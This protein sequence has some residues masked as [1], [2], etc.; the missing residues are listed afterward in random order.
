[1]PMT[2]ADHP[3]GAQRL[4]PVATAKNSATPPK[5]EVPFTRLTIEKNRSPWGKAVGDIDGDGFIDALA[6]F[7]DDAVY[8]YHYP[9]WTKHRIGQNGG[10]DLQVADL[11]GD[12]A[13]DV[14]TNGE[15]IVWYENPRCSGGNPASRS[16][17]RHVIDATTGSH[18]VTIGDLNGDGKLD[19]VTRVEFGPTFVYLQQGTDAWTKIA[20]P[21]ADDGNG[22][23]LLDV[24]HDGRIDL[25][26]N[27]YWLEHPS[28]P[29]NGVWVRH[30]FAGWP[31]G[32]SVMIGD[33]NHDGR[34]DVILSPSES[35]GRIAWFEMPVDPLHAPWIEHIILPTASYIH[36][37]RLADFNHDGHLDV[38]FAE[39]DQSGSNRI[40]IS[41]NDGTGTS[42]TLQVL[43]TS[44]G[45]NLAIGDFDNDGDVDIL[46][47][48]WRRSHLDL[49]RNDSSTGGPA[50]YRVL[51]FSKTAGFRHASIPDGIAAIQR[52]GATHHFMADATEDSTAFTDNQLA[53]YKAI[54][55]LNPSGDILD[56]GQRAAFQR[57]IEQG[58]GF[59]GIHNAAALLSPTMD[60][61]E[62]Y[63]KLVG[64][65]YHSE[66]PTQPMRL[67]VV[68]HAHPSTAGLPPVW[69]FTEEA[70]NFK[71]NPKSNGVTVL[72]SL[73]ES[74][75]N[76]GQMGA[77]HPFSWY[78]A[79]DNGRSWYTTGG[80]NAED[81]ANAF[82]LAHVLGGIQYAAGVVLQASIQSSV[83]SPSSSYVSTFYWLLR[84]MLAY[85]V[86]GVKQLLDA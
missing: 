37:L 50:P 47:A 24:N 75:V 26:E 20:I 80:A 58:G 29:V 15:Q 8:W 73:A 3:V 86:H 79:Y 32:C 30:D 5:L 23:A 77:D 22:L 44:A 39:M 9:S 59:V 61:W 70:Y 49:W 55:F 17:P 45:H 28:D 60:N 74:S 12:G 85:V 66:I 78:H 33:L 11:N 18:D 34:P 53:R 54:V 72:V 10:D 69:R 76:S 43:G 48:N 67:H 41:Y 38:A 4:S 6:G 56:A 52:L 46:N 57:Y 31:T 21:A 27:G 62:W 83:D 7:A 42:W 25:V 51:V 36:R 1:M 81:Y 35:A 16:W 14:V 2:T 63:N 64:A 40:G 13:P 19:V 71:H 84:D 68:T 65:Q 82:F